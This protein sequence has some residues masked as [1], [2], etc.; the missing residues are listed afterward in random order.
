MDRLAPWAFAEFVEAN[1]H[2][3]AYPRRRGLP[4]GPT[5]VRNGR[6]LVNFA[7]ISFLDLERHLPVRRYFAEGALAHGLS[8]SASR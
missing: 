3:T 6:E 4:V 5:I 2:D 1:T 7:S 8:T